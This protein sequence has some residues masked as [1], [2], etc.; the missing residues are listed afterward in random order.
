MS[1]IL[2]PLPWEKN[3]LAPHISQEAIEFHY[4]KHHKGY[5]HDL[6]MTIK[7]T[8]R[9]DLTLEELIK[10]E[11]PSK[12]LHVAGQA[13]NHT[14]YWHSLAPNAGGEPTGAIKNE[15]EKH[16]GGF[17]KFKEDFS[18]AAVGH[19]GSGWAWLVQN[20]QSR[21]LEIIQTHDGYPPIKDGLIP[22][23][24]CD[25]WEH[26]YYIDYRNQRAEYIKAF[27]NLVNWDFANKNLV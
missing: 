7:G 8:P 10:K 5:I 17:Q 26:A 13:W 14:F 21:K 9:Q 25:V 4:G 12:L 11:E 22:I 16:F 19:F 1:H 27:W 18:L 3:A 15:I 6:N 2:P 20:P 24:S 23:L